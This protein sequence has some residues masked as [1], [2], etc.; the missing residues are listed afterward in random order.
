MRPVIAFVALF[1]ALAAGCGQGSPVLVVSTS[2]PDAVVAIDGFAHPGASP[3]EIAFKE[4]GRYKLFVSRPGFRP[5]EMY[6]TLSAGAREKRTIELVQDTAQIADPFTQ[7]VPEPLPEPPPANGSFALAVTSSPAG[8][9]LSLREPGSTGVHAVGV[10]PTRIILPRDRATE[11][12]VSLP[13]YEDARRLVVAPE[14]G[15]DAV[16]DV[17]L[18][19]SGRAP[20]GGGTEP[21]HLA[22]PPRPVSDGA[23]G[24]LTVT[25]NPWSAVFLDGRPLGNTPVVRIAVPVGSHVVL[26]ENRDAGV[27]RKTGIVVRAGEEVRLAENLGPGD[28]GR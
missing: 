16:L 3:H 27:R 9:T 12:T 10:A 19:R 23:Y 24:L 14:S 11:V 6:V 7:P 4:P 22:E 28:M 20:V 5:V 17:I 13:G 8:A 15:G 26:M 18:E 2:P 25:T 21:L 1:A